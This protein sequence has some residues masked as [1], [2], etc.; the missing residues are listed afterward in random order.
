MH[1]NKIVSRPDRWGSCLGF[2]LGLGLLIAG[3]QVFACCENGECQYDTCCYAAGTCMQVG[4]EGETRRC[5]VVWYVPGQYYI[6]S[7]GSWCSGEP[8][9]AN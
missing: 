7:T 9:D 2:L 5:T 1:R 4:G 6:C 3:P 8:C